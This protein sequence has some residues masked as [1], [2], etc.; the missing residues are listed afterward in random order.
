MVGREGL[1]NG[2]I[3]WITS[4]GS[5]RP[6]SSRMATGSHGA[7]KGQCSGPTKV[8]AV[9][10]EFT[11]EESVEQG[12]LGGNLA[13]QEK[14]PCKKEGERSR[15][16]VQKRSH[17][18]KTH[19]LRGSRKWDAGWNRTARV[20]GGRGAHDPSNTLASMKDVSKLYSEHPK[21]SAARQLLNKAL[22]GFT[23]HLWNL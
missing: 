23:E 3:V 18:S 15:S 6:P 1:E 8:R 22:P 11:G 20:I 21:D 16:N 14:Q 7:S 12:G 17:V 19:E 9:M 2:R 13:V 10:W 4:Q 5:V